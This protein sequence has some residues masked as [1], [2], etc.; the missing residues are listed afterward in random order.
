MEV[1]HELEVV[2][3]R[4]KLCG[5]AQVELH[6]P[7]QVERLIEGIRLYAQRVRRARPLEERDGVDD[8]SG[9]GAGQ[10]ARRPEARGL[11]LACVPQR[12][13]RVGDLTCT[14][15]SIVV[16]TLRSRRSRS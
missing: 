10:K 5:R 11:R 15:A 13:Q 8:P 3:Q 14:S 2:D 4:P 1:A 9:V 7:V 6:A 12:E 16:P